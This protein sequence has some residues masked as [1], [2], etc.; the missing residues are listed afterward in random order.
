MRSL[1]ALSALAF[2]GC[3]AHP[4]APAAAAP[5]AA[6]QIVLDGQAPGA[7]GY[8]S[9][10]SRLSDVP[11][12]R[13]GVDSAGRF[14]MPAVRAGDYLAEIYLSGYNPGRCVLRVPDDLAAP[15]NIHL[16]RTRSEAPIESSL[17]SVVRCVRDRGRPN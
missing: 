8:I 13:I 11:I 9:L 6:G 4:Q 5:Q 17:T 14:S 15:I 10:S 7:A 12:A 16:N 2:L 1:F 3:A